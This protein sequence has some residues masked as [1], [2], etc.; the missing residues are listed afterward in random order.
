MLTFEQIAEIE[1]KRRA[2][3]KLQGLLTRQISWEFGLHTD[4]GGW[5]RLAYEYQ[6][7]IKEVV[8][9]FTIL[10]ITNLLEECA[11]LGVD[12]SKPREVLEKV[13]TEIRANGKD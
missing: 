12:V 2:I 13:L 9:K 1:T 8:C 7:L 11:I 10:N 5:Q 3:E 6:P 4:S